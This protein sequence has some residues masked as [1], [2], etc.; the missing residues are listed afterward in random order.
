MNRSDAVSDL[1]FLEQALEERFAYLKTP[2][3][4]HG[5]VDRRALFQALRQRLPATLEPAWLGL[6]LQKLLAHFI[7]GH[8]ATNVPPSPAGFLPF[9]TGA[10]SNP[11][12]DAQS[13]APGEASAN[14]LVAFQPDRSGFLDPGHPF[15]LAIDGLPA[16]R[17]LEGAARYAPRGS[18]QLVQRE[19][20]RWLRAV[21]RLREDLGLPQLDAVEVMLGDAERSSVRTL[22]LPVTERAPQFGVWPRRESALL[23]GNVGYLRLEQMR[24]AAAD[25]VRA[26]LERFADAEALI[27]DVRGNGGGTR[28]ALLAL[29][30][31]LL[32]EAASPRVV[33]VAAYRTWEGFPQDHLAARH[34][35]P[36]ESTPWQPR[37]RAV[38]DAFMRGFSPEWRPPVDEFSCWHA[39]VVSPTRPPAPRYHERPV[40]VLMDASC[41]SATDVFLSALKGL[42]NV[43]LVGEPSSGGSARA[44]VVELPNS[45][46][47]ARFASMASFQA[48]GEL[49]DGRG[50]QPDVMVTPDP[51]YF[52]EGGRDLVLERAQLLVLDRTR[53]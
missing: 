48:S 19:S 15:L 28:D 21:G 9:L 10:V 24:P 47:K 18:P 33:N 7:D 8:A 6:E 2:V 36:I 32:P 45:G 52:L 53:A 20:R 41:F 30:P 27:V 25:D 42:P 34:L 22:R 16:E 23:D 11:P 37:E 43:L 31:A 50:V 13:G 17:W 51:A 35:Y 46:I 1:A 4:D 29:L 40:A 14:A 38:L 44:Q 39:M 12:G 26:G 5:V 49:F 3:G